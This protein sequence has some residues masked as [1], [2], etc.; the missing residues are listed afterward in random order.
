MSFEYS[1]KYLIDRAY[2]LIKDHNDTVQLSKV[3]LIKPKIENINKKACII[4]FMDM[5]D[6]LQRS[7]YDVQIYINKE[8][9]TTSSI[10]D[11]GSLILDGNFKVH[12]VMAQIAEY[13]NKY[14]ICQECK[15]KHTELEK[16]D[17]IL[18]MECS[19]CKAKKSIY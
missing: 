18:Y 15:S 6:N 10:V 5:C 11:S 14:V 3:T 12:T 17:K 4:N 8:L 9:M 13:I 1:E 19:K 2:K 16:I 7:H